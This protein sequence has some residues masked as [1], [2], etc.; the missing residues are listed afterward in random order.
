[1]RAG[2]RGHDGRVS[3]DDDLRAGRHQI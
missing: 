3:R 2:Q 1:L